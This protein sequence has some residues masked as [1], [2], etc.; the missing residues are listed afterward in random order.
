MPFFIFDEKFDWKNCDLHIYYTSY[1]NQ[2]IRI[3]RTY[4]IQCD[5]IISTS[6]D[7][8]VSRDNDI[9]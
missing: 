3:I 8:L 9:I 2:Y 4:S 7:G 6:N 1:N 5:L